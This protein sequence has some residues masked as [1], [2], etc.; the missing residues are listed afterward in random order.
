MNKEMSDV[1]QMQRR[2]VQKVVDPIKFLIS[3]QVTGFGDKRRLEFERER[4]LIT[5]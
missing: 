4:K 3:V 5:K 1:A 2:R